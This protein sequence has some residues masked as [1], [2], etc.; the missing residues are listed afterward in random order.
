M[1]RKIYRVLDA[2]RR[3]YDTGI[4]GYVDQAFWALYLRPMGAM[5]Q[6]PIICYGFYRCGNIMDT[7]RYVNENDGKGPYRVNGGPA[8]ISG[9]FRFSHDPF[10]S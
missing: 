3:G 10:Q 2:V 6:Y 8:V 7:D 9:P 1:A 4:A 5:I